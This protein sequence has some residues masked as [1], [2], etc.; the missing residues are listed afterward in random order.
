MWGE[1]AG[2]V[3]ELNQMLPSTD[4]DFIPGQSNGWRG[5]PQAVETVQSAV[6]ATKIL[7]D[8][9]IFIVIDEQIYTI[10]GQRI[11]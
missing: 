1:K 2:Q 7:K 11:Q 4:P 3:V 8:G 9:Q 6:R 10:T 5:D